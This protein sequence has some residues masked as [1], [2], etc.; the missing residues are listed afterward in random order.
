MAIQESKIQNPKSK[1]VL[2]GFMASGKTTVAKALSER[3]D[4][5]FVDLDQFIE[6][7]E[8][9][10]IASIID[11]EG[12]ARFRALETKALRKILENNSLKIIALGGGTWTI[13]ENR[14]LISEHDCLTVWLDVPFEACWE[15]IIQT[16][17]TRPL[18]RNK[19][20]TQ[21]LFE[22]R[23]MIYSLADLSITFNRETK[24]ESTLA[25]ISK[26][27]VI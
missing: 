23:R 8:N 11:T 26:Y 2:I 22:G 18:A 21:K 10:T 15:R 5:D 1:I 14:K 6:S 24:L 12:E 13:E 17:D 19:E 20:K 25:L 9:K 16:G 7:R 27:F 4:C 3:L